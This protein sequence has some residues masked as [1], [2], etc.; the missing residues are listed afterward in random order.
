MANPSLSY[1]D[2]KDDEVERRK[3][4]GLPKSHYI[5]E[6]IQARFNAEDAGEWDT[7]EIEPPATESPASQ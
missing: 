3:L 6:A 1:P 5:R 7:P 2:W 4:D